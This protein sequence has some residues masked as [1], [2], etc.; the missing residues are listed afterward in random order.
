[1]ADDGGRRRC[2]Q[3]MPHVMLTGLSGRAPAARPLRTRAARATRATRGGMAPAGGE[4]VSVTDSVWRLC[5]ELP[6]RA[7]LQAF[8][9]D[10]EN[11]SILVGHKCQFEMLHRIVPPSSFLQRGIPTDSDAHPSRKCPACASNLKLNKIQTTGPQLA[12]P[13]PRALGQQYIMS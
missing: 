10:L 11:K 2:Q 6:E 1:M 12:K 8:N 13:C 5:T 3:R 4:A 7:A 9:K